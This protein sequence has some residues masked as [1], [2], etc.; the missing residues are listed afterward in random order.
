MQL[1]QDLQSEKILQNDPFFVFSAQV[2]SI[3]E[4]TYHYLPWG[5]RKKKLFTWFGALYIIPI[6]F[7]YSC[8]GTK[9]IVKWSRSVLKTNYGCLNYDCTHKTVFT[10]TNLKRKDL[11]EKE[12]LSSLVIKD[13]P[14]FKGLS[15]SIICTA[16]LL[17]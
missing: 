11:Q 10:T 15:N 6:W 14:F 2:Q 1:M 17:M 9:R 3:F 13:N 4:V 12:K 5:N 16:L 7:L 8:N